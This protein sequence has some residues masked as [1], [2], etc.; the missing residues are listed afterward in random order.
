MENQ[1]VS[2]MEDLSSRL[3][4]YSISADDPVV[5]VAKPKEDADYDGDARPGD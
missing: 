4:A 2:F 5:P 3:S 1:D